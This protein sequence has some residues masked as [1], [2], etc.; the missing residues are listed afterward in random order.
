MAR[1]FILNETQGDTNR[2][3]GTYGYMA[4]E[5]AMHGKFSV[6]SDVYSFGILLLEIIS[7]QKYNRFCIGGE[8]YELTSFAWDSWKVGTATNMIDPTIFSGPRNDI[9]RIIHIGL[10]C[11]QDSVSARP[12]MASV[13]N[14]FNNTSLSLPLPSK[15]AYL[16]T[17]ESEKTITSGSAGKVGAQSVN[18]ISITEQLPK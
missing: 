8:P 15:P 17:I 1:L 11:V 6:K 7:G 18:W 3:V 4:P 13:I 2:I 12:T 16:A 14:M 5:Y 10:L 9:L